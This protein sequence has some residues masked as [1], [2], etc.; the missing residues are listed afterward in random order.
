[1][2]CSIYKGRK[3]PDRYLFVPAR[4]G[5][6]G[7]PPVV[8]EA[9]G[10]LEHVMDLVLTPERRL[11]RADTLRVMRTMLLQGCYVQLPPGT[12]EEPPLDPRRR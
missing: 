8:L 7:L 5:F 11:A 2:H 6:A 10:E 9:F 4:D 1:M 3:A 12:P